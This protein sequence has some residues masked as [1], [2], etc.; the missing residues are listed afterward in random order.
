[1]SEGFGVQE[2]VG[3]VLRIVD[4]DGNK[5]QAEKF[6]KHITAAEL[7]AVA[8][9]KESSQKR[10]D[11]LKAEAGEKL[12]IVAKTNK[13]FVETEKKAT[14]AFDT[15]S[16]KRVE[17]GK[18]EGNERTTLFE[19]VTKAEKRS[20]EEGLRVIVDNA[21]KKKQVIDKETRDV[22]AAEKAKQEK[23]KLAHDQQM[24]GNRRATESSIGALQGAMDLAEGLAILGLA[25]EENF[26]AFARG[27]IKVQATFKAVKGFTELI[28]KA[29]EALLA[30]QSAQVAATAGAELLAETSVVAGGATATAAAANSIG[31]TGVGIAG[32]AAGTAVGQTAAAV[33]AR[34]AGGSAAGNLVGG[35]VG[36][37]AAALAGKALTGPTVGS[38]LKG[39]GSAIVRG[40]KAL[41]GGV[42]A[43]GGL[44]AGVSAGA[45]ATGAV[46]AGGLTESIGYL[47]SGGGEGRG[48]YDGGGL[49]DEG[50]YS[51]VTGLL[52]A[53]KQEA[54]SEK[55]ITEAEKR[56]QEQIERNALFQETR[57]SNYSANR[58][59]RSS[60]SGFAAARITSGEGTETE[61]LKKLE[62]KAI[63]EISEARKREAETQDQQRKDQND[64]IGFSSELQIATIDEIR[65]K[66]A[67]VLSI[68]E[69]VLSISKAQNEE[70]KRA[71]ENSTTE[72]KLAKE[73]LQ[74]AQEAAKA[75]RDSK[76][77]TFDKLTAQQKFDVKEIAAKKR[78]GEEL[79]EG[80]ITKLESAGLRKEADKFRA[81][82]SQGATEDLRTLG[83]F[84]GSDK[85]VQTARDAETA[86]R[87]KLKKA[88]EDENKS[89][90]E[91]AEQSKRVAEALSNLAATVE[92]INLAQAEA[93][94]NTLQPVA[95]AINGGTDSAVKDNLLLIDAVKKMNDSNA[96]NLRLL[97]EEFDKAAETKG[98][99][100]K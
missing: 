44:T 63:A 76:L 73:K 28:W 29:R 53:R 26:E 5:A 56:K 74:A 65:E 17:I 100:K 60:R 69:N 85:N 67:Q 22:I 23:I 9:A 35:A 94:G 41:W 57:M 18:R 46:I 97:R 90:Q 38:I 31:A 2:T 54:Q 43:L 78:N 45:A 66:E 16:R 89:K 87:E 27:F 36:G 4:E 14:A 86:S 1:M 95:D 52:G 25:S 70:H 82:R 98:A 33:A 71:V 19:T 11:I 6:K 20:S 15:E 49:Y 92:R 81:N 24:D 21:E 80:D 13:T 55:N 58:A 62:I 77:V 48:L 84:E 34:R 96:E 10:I 7:H 39:T 61:K 37:A 64:R 51:A 50:M 42:Q 68:R 12:G 30:M 8:V 47:R 83:E 91:V 40:G 99:Y 3:I 59:A 88:I 75:D 32:D 79:T 93:S 72:L